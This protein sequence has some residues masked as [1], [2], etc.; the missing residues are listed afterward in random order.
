MCCILTIQNQ[1]L[2]YKF[3]ASELLDKKENKCTKVR[4]WTVSPTW[5]KLIIP[6]L[7]K[8]FLTLKVTRTG[9]G[10]ND[11]SYSVTPFVE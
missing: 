3:Y 4:E 6:L 7:L 1:A 11:T 8:G 10:I 2:Q 5:A 9:S